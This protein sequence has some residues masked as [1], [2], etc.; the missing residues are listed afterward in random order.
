MW[1]RGGPLRVTLRSTRSNQSPPPTWRRARGTQADDLEADRRGMS[2]PSGASVPG[3]GRG[4]RSSSAPVPAPSRIGFSLSPPQQGREERQEEP[5]VPKKQ[6][7]RA[8]SSRQPHAAAEPPP[9]ATTLPTCSHRNS[10][11]ERGAPPTWAQQ[12]KTTCWVT[13]PSR[14]MEK[15]SASARRRAGRQRAARC[16]SPGASHART[17]RPMPSGRGSS[18]PG[19]SRPP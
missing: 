12:P 19:V 8:G 18:R 9:Q 5:Q 6:S 17:R 10:G 14:N 13:S 15:K 16:A 3:R 7:F 4:G 1:R 11:C 2:A